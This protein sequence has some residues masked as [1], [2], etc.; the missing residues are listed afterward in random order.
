MQWWSKLFFSSL[1][2]LYRRNRLQNG[3]LLSLDDMMSESLVFPPMEGLFRLELLLALLLTLALTPLPS[4]AGM[5]AESLPR[6]AAD[7]CWSSKPSYSSD[8]S[9]G[10]APCETPCSNIF[11]TLSMF[12]CCSCLSVIPGWHRKMQWMTFSP[13]LPYKVNK[14]LMAAVAPLD[15]NNRRQSWQG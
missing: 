1:H 3:F 9:L 6:S 10:N 13:S 8:D 2:I 12:C 11:V 4:T 7:G 15:D 14:C 5:K